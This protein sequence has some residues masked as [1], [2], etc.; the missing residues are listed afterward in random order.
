[1]RPFVP[2]DVQERFLKRA[3]KVAAERS[4]DPR[5]QNGVVI[6]SGQAFVTSAA[7]VFPMAGW[8]QWDEPPEKYTFIEHAERSAIHW[9]ARVGCPLEGTTMYA[10]WAACPDCARAIIDAGITKLVC[11]TKPRLHTP[12]RWM[13]A[14]R[15][16]DRMLAD[17]GVQIELADPDIGI[18]IQ[19]DGRPLEL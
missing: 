10:V 6:A 15:I 3:A 1:M 13:T 5:T 11:L 7:N 19:F 4:H 9:A 18:T 8:R 12:D 2:P 14:I 17:A 16:G